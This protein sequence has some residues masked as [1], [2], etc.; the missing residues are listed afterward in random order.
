MKGGITPLEVMVKN[1]RWWDD[2][3]EGLLRQLLQMGDQVASFDDAD[4]L[5]EFFKIIEKVGIYR[6]K[7]EECAVDAAPYM[8]PKLASIVLKGDKDNPIE[9]TIAGSDLKQLAS[10][11]ATSLKQESKEPDPDPVTAEAAE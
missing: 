2:S 5:R 4:L 1:M 7:A 3:A 11:Y 9:H 8:H 10:I 6:D